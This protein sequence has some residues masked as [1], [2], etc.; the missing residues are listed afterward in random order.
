MTGR[1]WADWII[2]TAAVLTAALVIWQKGIRPVVRTIAEV[3]QAVPI[4][5]DIAQE[6]R[7]NSGHSLRDVIDDMRS[8]LQTIAESQATIIEDHQELK[9]AHAQLSLQIRNVEQATAPGVPDA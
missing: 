7:P 6:F 8:S 3:A 2:L 9:D 1:S 5:A 4:L